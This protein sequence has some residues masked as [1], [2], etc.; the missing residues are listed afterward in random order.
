[1]AHLLKAR[2]RRFWLVCSSVSSLTKTPTA[3]SPQEAVRNAA[4]VG[5]LPEVQRCVTEGAPVHDTDYQA[6]ES[7]RAL[8]NALVCCDQMGAKHK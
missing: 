3:C 8:M 7:P 6:R 2:E 4:M 1:M 5:D